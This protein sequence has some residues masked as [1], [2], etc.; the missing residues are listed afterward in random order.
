MKV[1][2]LCENQITKEDGFKIG[3][4]ISIEN[5]RYTATCMKLEEDGA[6]FCMD[7]QFRDPAAMDFQGHEGYE[8]SM[9]R[10][11]LNRIFKDCA[12]EDI[13][14]YMIPFEN[15]D[16]LRI[17]TVEEI[18]G[19]DRWELMF[20]TSYKISY[21]YTEAFRWGYWLQNVAELGN[22]KI[23]TTFYCVDYR[24]NLSQD[25]CDGLN[26]VRVVFKIKHI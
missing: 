17:P 13:R 6:I 2:R 10:R 12:F 4:I 26:G 9:L 23:P 1:M 3:D 19:D 14:T 22:S 11:I 21:P 15:G 18:F 8:K 7:Q 16:Y 5:E 20:R 25:R 24:G